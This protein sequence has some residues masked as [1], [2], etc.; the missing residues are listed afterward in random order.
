MH[1]S[2]AMIVFIPA[3]AALVAV[4][5]VLVYV[6]ALRR[7]FHRHEWHEWYVF[8][9]S[10]ICTIG[11][12]EPPRIVGQQIMMLCRCGATDR[13]HLATWTDARLARKRLPYKRWD[14]YICVT[15]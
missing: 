4:L 12:D 7:P 10:T 13:K 3:A 1:L 5:A 14:L 11:T 8:D 15:H 2:P 6:G 9:S